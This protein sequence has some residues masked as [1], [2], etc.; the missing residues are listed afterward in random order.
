MNRL[1]QWDQ[2][3][4][5]AL[6]V[7]LSQVAAALWLDHQREQAAEAAS[8]S[9]APAIAPSPSPGERSHHAP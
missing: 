5:L 2:L 4:V 6:V 7:I 9:T 1:A 8:T 3:A